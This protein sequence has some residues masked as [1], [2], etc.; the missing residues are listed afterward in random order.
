MGGLNRK[1]N[2]PAGE[3]VS[4]FSSDDC[5]EE[6]SQ[7][8]LDMQ[9]MQA[10]Y[11]M[12]VG[13]F[14]WMCTCTF[15]HLAYVTMVLS[16]FTHNP[17]KAHFRAALRVLV[18][19]ATV[20]VQG[21]TLGGKS[22]PV[23]RMWV[24]AS[25]ND[26]LSVTGALFT[27]GHSLINWFTRRQS[28]VTRSSMEAETFAAADCATEGA[29]ERD[30]ITELQ[31]NISTTSIFCDAKSTIDFAANRFACKRSKAFVRDTNFLRD[32][33]ARLVIAFKKVL[34]SLN[35]ADAMTKALA[36]GPFDLHRNAMLNANMVPPDVPID[37]A[38][39]LEIAQWAHFTSQNHRIGG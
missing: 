30:L 2:T 13:S 33:V 35:H 19:L 9:S 7:E 36:I 20:P 4:H 38:S 12:L 29:Y 18:Y 21:L 28:R 17:S 34:T 14:L 23:Y 24:D 3:E 39:R 31:G 15:P 22:D 1:F 8:Q 10:H 25:W 6:G 37:K 26:E 5:P 32:W 11:M 16:R 27:Y